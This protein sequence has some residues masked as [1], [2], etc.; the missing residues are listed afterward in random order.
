MHAEFTKIQH[1]RRSQYKLAEQA[2]LQSSE[3][4]TFQ[5]CV[6]IMSILLSSCESLGFLQL[7]N[8]YAKEENQKV[9]FVS[10]PYPFDYQL[11][12]HA[13]FMLVKIKVNTLKEFL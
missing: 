2:D 4:L 6:L 1:Y 7:R 3:T 9:P 5:R 11:Y 12:I 13:Y 10:S 8:I